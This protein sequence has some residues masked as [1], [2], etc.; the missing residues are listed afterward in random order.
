M[1]SLAEQ[2]VTQL[3]G[4]ISVLSQ[5]KR[6]H[7]RLDQLLRRLDSAAGGE[8]RSILR[9]I[10]RLVFPHAFAEEAI[11]WPTIRRVLPDGEALTLRVEVEHQ[12]INELVVQLE[13]L[14]AGSAEHRQLLA[15][16]VELLRTDV[17]DE[18]DVLLA[19]LQARLSVGQLQ[20][21]GLA[22]GAIRW[23]APTRAHPLVARRP[24][25]NILSAAPLSVLD[26]CRD[27]V[28]ARLVRQDA[29][30]AP[31]L[32]SLSAALARAAHAVER[33]PGLR[34]GEH[35]ATRR[36]P[37]S[38]RGRAVV[39]VAVVAIAGALVIRRRAALAA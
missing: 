27:R 9:A 4:P 29:T 25:G 32:R 18:E 14:E 35:P 28:D 26:R 23:I 15:R 36:P 11:L 12:Q 34:M 21:L 13:A 5:Q 33:L 7:V 22:W 8:Q 6:D 19:R 20:R 17:R 3:G 16:I 30:G 10:Y 31:W 39:M 1:A 24:L 2:S 38:G 37:T